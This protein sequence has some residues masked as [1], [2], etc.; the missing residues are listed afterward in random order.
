M[1]RVYVLFKQCC[2]YLVLV[3]CCCM[4]DCM[5]WRVGGFFKFL[6]EIKRVDVFKGKIILFFNIFQLLKNNF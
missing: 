6:R 5:S 2:C 1:D 3:Y 4:F